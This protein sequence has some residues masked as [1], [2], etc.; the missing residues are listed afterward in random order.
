MTP[1][2]IRFKAEAGMVQVEVDWVYGLVLVI[3]RNRQLQRVKNP[4]PDRN[5]M[6]IGM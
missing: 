4:L 2:Y 5:S 6:S 1:S 3:E